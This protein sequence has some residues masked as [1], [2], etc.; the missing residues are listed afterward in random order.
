MSG[1]AARKWS[2]CVRAFVTL[3]RR[4]WNSVRRNQMEASMVENVCSL[5]WWTNWRGSRRGGVWTGKHDEG[6]EF[7]SGV[8][9]VTTATS[10]F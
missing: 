5:K 4:N 2:A 6:E 10:S 8:T 7:N 9:N 1:M 3:F